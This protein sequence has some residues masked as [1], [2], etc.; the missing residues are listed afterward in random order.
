VIVNSWG[1]IKKIGSATLAF[2]LHVE[3]DTATATKWDSEEYAMHEF[4]IGKQGSR[5]RGWWRGDL[6][7]P[8]PRTDPSVSAR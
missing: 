8:P 1:A 5:F 6:H 4:A 3:L 7:A 2:S